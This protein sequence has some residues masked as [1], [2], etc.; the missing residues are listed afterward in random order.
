MA[1]D[2]SHTLRRVLGLVG[3]GLFIGL[4]I[5]LW[6]HPGLLAQVLHR[7]SEKAFSDPAR[8]DLTTAPCVATFADGLQVRLAVQ[9][10]GFSAG[11]VLSWQVA[12][13]PAGESAPP[14][15]VSALEVTGVSMPMGLTTINMQSVD[16]GW[17]GQGTLPMCTA[18]IMAWQADVVLRVG[19]QERVAGFLFH[20]H[21][22][23]AVQVGPGRGAA[24]PDAADPTFGDFQVNTTLGPLRLSELHGRAVLL[25]F[26]YT[27]CPD[28]CPTTLADLAQ[29]VR[30]LPGGRPGPRHGAGGHTGPGPRCIAA[31]A[32]V[33]EL[34]PPGLPRRGHLRGRRAGRH[35]SGLGRGLAQDPATRLD[36]RA[37]PSTMRPMRSS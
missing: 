23:V 6:R 18:S 7:G 24:A 29:A 31:P 3:W 33:R 16:A 30:A 25:Y 26:G 36:P 37:T 35:H 19:G 1:D 11:Q 17:Q 5:G 4:L 15:A 22:D 10:S 27:A 2:A 14:V 28:V 34:V 8:C 32:G 20:T 13:D 12:V 21:R 9:P